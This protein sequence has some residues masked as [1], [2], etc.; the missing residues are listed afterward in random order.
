MTFEHLH[1]RR[2]H[3]TDRAQQPDGDVANTSDGQSFTRGSQQNRL[4]IVRAELGQRLQTLR[5]L[6]L[7]LSRHPADTPAVYAES[8]SEAIEHLEAA[9]SALARA[10][11]RDSC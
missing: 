9:V 3:G 11:H 2:E 1:W 5:L 4:G 7:E 10:R 8:L 6:Q